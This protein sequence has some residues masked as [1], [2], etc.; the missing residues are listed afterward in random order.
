[1]E[2]QKQIEG[3]RCRDNFYKPKYSEKR[4]VISEEEFINEIDN[5]QSHN[6]SKFDENR[7]LEFLLNK[8]HSTT[9]IVS[10]ITLGSRWQYE[11]QNLLFYHWYERRYKK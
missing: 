2:Y 3:L 5:S 10:E 9:K 11:Q 1:M 6:A 8:A 4:I 7:T